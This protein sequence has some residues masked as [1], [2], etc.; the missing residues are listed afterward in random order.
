MVF[1][2]NSS[3]LINLL[4]LSFFFST[5]VCSY[6]KTSMT[7]RNL[8]DGVT[9]QRK[10]K[11]STSS[12]GISTSLPNPSTMNKMFEYAN[13]YLTKKITAEETKIVYKTA[14]NVWR[15][16]IGEEWFPTAPGDHTCSRTLCRFDCLKAFFVLQRGENQS[17]Y[18]HHIC[19]RVQ[20]SDDAKLYCGGAVSHA[21]YLANPRNS[22]WITGNVS[23]GYVCHKTGQLHICHPR[24]CSALMGNEQHTSGDE[25]FNACAITGITHGGVAMVH[26]FWKPTSI[27]AS[28]ESGNLTRREVLNGRMAGSRLR[29]S[30]NYTF[31]FTWTDLMT[32]IQ[33]R[34]IGQLDTPLKAA[35]IIRTLR[36]KRETAQDALNEYMVWAYMRVASLFSSARFDYDLEKSKKVAAI[37]ERQI[38]K[39]NR[40]ADHMLTVEEVRVMQLDIL[41]RNQMPLTLSLDDTKH[42]KFIMMYA[43]RCVLFWG[44]ICNNTCAEDVTPAKRVTEMIFQNFVIASMY[45]FSEGLFL[46]ADVTKSVSGEWI[47]HADKLLEWTLPRLSSIGHFACDGNVIALQKRVISHIIIQAV[48]DFGIDPSKLTPE[49]T[50]LSNLGIDILPPLHRQRDCLIRK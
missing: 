11:R 42:H 39:Y 20:N 14:L 49:S 22:M 31:G 43:S 46:P 2:Q 7:T 10:R 40:S 17:S 45:I 1:F 15:D 33:D 9:E 24:L 47:M 4:Q 35:D 13:E 3:S 23:D 21:K 19:V 27:A 36:P 26:K 28:S 48:R 32:K 37:A 41:E 16:Q 12:N 29:S 34:S 30:C 6:Y 25:S 5:S 18:V 38:N 44:T 50:E 8:M